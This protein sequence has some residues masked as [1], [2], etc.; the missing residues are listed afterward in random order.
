[1]NKSMP[2]EVKERR[3]KLEKAI[4]KHRHLYHTLDKP[5]IN[6]EAYDSLVKEFEQIEREYPEL[7]T[8]KGQS[9]RVGGE[10]LKGFVKVK[11][12][13]QQWSFDDVFDFGELKKW[14]E[15]VRNFMVKAGIA[16]EELE[17]CCELK[18]DG[19]KVVL[20]YEH[21]V[22]QQAATRGDGVTGED[23]THNVKTIESVPLH[24]NNGKNIIVEGEVW[25]SKSELAR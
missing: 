8:S 2:K 20:T 1:M 23:V 4:E 3:N 13:I 5:E 22:L 15:K 14:N 11:H 21:G 10:P 24:L 16:D 7:K 9:E 19:L 18:I 12:K 6:D 25:I 17:Y